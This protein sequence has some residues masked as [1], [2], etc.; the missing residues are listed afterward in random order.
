MEDN[1]ETS[2]NSDSTELNFG[3]EIVKTFAIS[4]AV[5][6]GVVAG[7][8]VVGLVMTKFEDIRKNRAAKKDAAKLTLVKN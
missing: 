2:E 4:T 1:F 5:S 6:T 8:V 3:K 7:F